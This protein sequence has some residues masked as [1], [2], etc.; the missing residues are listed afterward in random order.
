MTDRDAFEAM[1]TRA[2]VSFVENHSKRS[3][4]CPPARDHVDF[5]VR[6]GIGGSEAGIA[7]AYFK[8][9]GSLDGFHWCN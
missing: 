4:T 1:L 9:D 8:D 3:K 2:K 5:F 7:T 6:G